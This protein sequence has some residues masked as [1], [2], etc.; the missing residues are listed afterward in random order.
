MARR[1][2]GREVQPKRPGYTMKVIT[3]NVLVLRGNFT[4]LRRGDAAQS[5]IHITP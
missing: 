3:C 1:H 2:G 5:S 4:N